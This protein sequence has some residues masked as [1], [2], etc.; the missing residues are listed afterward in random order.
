MEPRKRI[1]SKKYFRLFRIL[2]L[3]GFPTALLCAFVFREL[4][5]RWTRIFPECIFYREYHLYCP[6]CGNTRS[7]L[8]LLHGD[9]VS[10]LEYNVT[11]IFL[12]IIALAF[13]CEAIAQTFGK[14][15]ALV[16]RKMPFMVITI[17]G[18]I[19]YFAARNFIPGLFPQNI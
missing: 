3:A 17:I 7:V 9:I 19:V 1:G 5:A 16:P 11:P 4:L 8:S 12:L 2:F 6:S 10:S 14:R 15:L 18:F 13:Y